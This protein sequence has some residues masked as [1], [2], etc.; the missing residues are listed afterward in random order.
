MKSKTKKVTWCIPNFPRA[1][2]D[3]FV[4]LVKMRGL[5]V[6]DVLETLIAKYVRDGRDE[7]GM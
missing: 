5:Y 7:E 1:L 6:R 4:G 2:K 3:Q